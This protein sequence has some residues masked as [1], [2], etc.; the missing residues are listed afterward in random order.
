V[1][2]AFDDVIRPRVIG[3]QE[4][5]TASLGETSRGPSGVALSVMV[6]LVTGHRVITVAVRSRTGAM[7]NGSQAHQV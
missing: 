1:A 4:R 6:S 3:S 7:N 5:M 2:E